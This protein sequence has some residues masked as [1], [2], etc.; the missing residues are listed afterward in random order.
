MVG[1]ITAS[2]PAIT[3][4]ALAIAVG[5]A[6]VRGGA[7]RMVTA[8]VGDG[9][10]LF[11]LGISGL[12]N[13]VVGVLALT[14]PA[15]TV[16]VLAVLVGVR[17][18]LFGV[19]Q[20]ALAAKLRQAPPGSAVAIDAAAP[21]SRWPRWLRL[22]GASTALVLAVG[23]LAIS[24]A[25][26][27][28]AP[29]A[30][31]SF[32]TAPSPLPDGPPGTIIRTEVI[33]GFHDGA[34]TYRLLYTST[35]YDGAPTAVSG[36][37]VVPDG[38]APAEG[39]NVITLTHGTVGVA[40]NCSPSLQGRQA[41]PV[42]EGLDESRRRRVRGR[43]HRLPRPR[44]SRTPPVPGRTVRSDEHARQRAGRPQPE[45][46]VALAPCF[47]G[48]RALT[49]TRPRRRARRGRMD[50]RALRRRTSAEHM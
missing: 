32:Y 11:V 28:S 45:R 15:V 20:V 13:V 49:S 22:T 5:I 40:T 2:W 34:T 18:I 17:T 37:V 12:T 9:D 46:R 29:G 43:C 27:R 30:P 10:E 16:L 14:W 41:L 7:I 25:V 4:L 33:D 24:V 31:G 44:D 6:L 38:A 42:Y 3:T 36:I 26:H 48:C 50:R 21:E 1:L 19:S 23:G 39:H 35:G 47:R 8:L